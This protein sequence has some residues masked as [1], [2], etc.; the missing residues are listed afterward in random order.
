MSPDMDDIGPFRVSQ[1][2]QSMGVGIGYHKETFE[3]VFIKTERIAST[4]DHEATIL[5][6]LSGGIGIPTLYWFGKAYNQK[7]MITDA[8]G[9]SLEEIFDRSN[10]YFDM[11]LVLEVASQLIFRL[12]WMHS[13]HIAHGQLSPF[14]FA[15]G[16]STWQTPQVILADFTNVNS[17]QFSTKKDLQAVADILVYLAIGPPSWDLFQARKPSLA[18]IPSPLK[19]FVSIISDR[20]MNPADYIILRRYFHTARQSLPGR[21][22]LGGLGS[23]QGEKLSLKSLASKSTGDLFENLGSRIST[24]G[25]SAGDP[26]APWGREQAKF[27][28]GSLNEIMTIYFVLLMREKPSQKR[29]HYHM[30]VYHLPNRLWRDLRWYLCMAKCGSLPLQR[31]IVLTIY[32]YVGV[33][34]EVIPVYNRYWTKIL[35]DAAYEQMKLDEDCWRMWRDAWMYWKNCANLLTKKDM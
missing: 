18:E 6:T 3:E 13:H 35:S 28:L 20:E 34:L 29:R 21:T 23:P 32:K 33:L 9:P 27:L 4:L 12:E 19:G 5:Q 26:K 25:D 16:A 1:W 2:L 10:R 31:L 17:S 7:T 24:V 15:M 11:P 22:I 30:G 14:S 8:L